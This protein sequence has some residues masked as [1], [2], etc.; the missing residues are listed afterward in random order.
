ML[1]KKKTEK[2]ILEE[3]NKKSQLNLSTETVMYLKG[4]NKMIDDFERVEV[5]FWSL[6]NDLGL[7]YNKE[8]KT[9]YSY[10]T[11]DKISQYFNT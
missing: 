10:K 5:D 8:N 6:I 2:Q 11:N 4:E 1:S 9:W 7:T 3:I